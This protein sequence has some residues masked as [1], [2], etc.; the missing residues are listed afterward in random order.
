MFRSSK[1]FV[2]IDTDSIHSRQIRPPIYSMKQ[3]KLR[4]RRVTRYAILYFLLLILYVVLIAAPIVA[5]RFLTPTLQG[6]NV[7]NLIQ[8]VGL[9]N[10]FTT[11][12]Q[13]GTRI[14]PQLKKGETPT[15]SNY[16]LLL[17]N[18]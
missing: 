18:F 8:P 9:H 15:P 17:R 1:H 6:M 2:E 3:S 10:N 16:K 7:M 14:A 13:T 11:N 5:K 12:E 4:K